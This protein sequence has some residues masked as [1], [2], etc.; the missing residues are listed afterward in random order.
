MPPKDLP[1]GPVPKEALKYFEA[2]NIE[3]GFD[4]RDVWGEEHNT[5]FTIAKVMEHDVLAEMK[6]LT[7]RAIKDGLSF[8]EFKAQAPK[9]LAKSGWGKYGTPEA[10]NTRLRTIFETNRRVARSAGQWQRIQRTKKLRPFLVYE[11]GPSTNHREEHEI[12]AGTVLPV[13][14]PFW[15]DHFVPN[16]WGCKCTIRQLSHRE[17]ERIGG[18]TPRPDTSTVK[19][20]N[21]HTGKIEN[22]PKG[23][24]PGWNYNPGINRNAGVN[25]SIKATPTPKGAEP[26]PLLPGG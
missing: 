5:A 2:K 24:G 23:I 11:L 17:V 13:D 1:P 16:G 6:D 9:L 22:V 4:H 15:A 3:P 26:I 7:H 8:D 14:D 20:E 12:W 10:T 25:E 21:K 19:W 18:V